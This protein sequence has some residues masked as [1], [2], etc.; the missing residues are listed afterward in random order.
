[1]TASCEEDDLLFIETPLSSLLWVV[2]VHTPSG[3]DGPGLWYVPGWRS[4]VPTW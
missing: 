2:H 4:P 3:F 1:M